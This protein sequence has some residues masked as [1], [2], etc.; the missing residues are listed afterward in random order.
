TPAEYGV[1]VTLTSL[2]AMS[3]PMVNWGV[4][5]YAGVHYFR[6]DPQ[7]F[8]ITLASALLIPPAMTLVLLLFLV[9]ASD[10]ISR[11]LHVPAEWVAVIP[12]LAAS[13]FLPFLIQ[14]LMRM[15][16]QPFSYAGMELSGALIDFAMTI[17]LV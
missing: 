3:T 16:N 9:P 1:M 5:A 12:L 7:K 17:V 6:D 13:S 8:G 14:T 10:L 2:I 4:P 11:W 15:H